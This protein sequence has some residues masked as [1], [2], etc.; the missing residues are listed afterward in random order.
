MLLVGLIHA[1]RQGE[2]APS[3]PFLADPRLLRGRMLKLFLIADLN[4]VLWRIVLYDC[5]N[6][7]K[8]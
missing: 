5:N 3:P 7:I 4:E 1:I 8:E 2:L 6:P